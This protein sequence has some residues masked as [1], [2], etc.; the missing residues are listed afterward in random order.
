MP[1]GGPRSGAGRKGGSPN[2]ASAQRQAE[3]AATGITPLEYML[4][5]MRD[6]THMPDVRLD[7]AKSAAPYVHPKLAS[8]EHSGGLNTTS[9]EEA[10]AALDDLGTRKGD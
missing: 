7:A 1:R 9:H 2:K 4:A 5:I 6:E 3:V 8:I 10:L